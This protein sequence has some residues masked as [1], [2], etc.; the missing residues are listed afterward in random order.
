MHANAP[1]RDTDGDG[2]GNRCDA[3]F[4]NDGA[5]NF[6]DLAYLKS[7]FFSTDPHADLNGDG[8]VNFADLAILKSFFFSTPGP[9]ALDP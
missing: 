8:A 9:S 1:Q 3:D 5:V 4:N 2:Y 7:A 6:S